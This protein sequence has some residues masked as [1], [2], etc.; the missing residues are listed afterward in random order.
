M[1]VVL[2][3][4]PSASPGPAVGFEQMYNETVFQDGTSKFFCSIRVLAA[5]RRKHFIAFHVR[6]DERIDID[7]TAPAVIGKD[8][9]LAGRIAAVES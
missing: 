2:A 1:L 9:G 3:V 6:I 4:R 8:T 5:R 7:G